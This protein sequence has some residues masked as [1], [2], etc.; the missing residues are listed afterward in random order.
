MS[1]ALANRTANAIHL[2]TTFDA[3]GSTAA[4][5]R[6]FAMPAVGDIRNR[7][8][9]LADTAVLP[10]R[11]LEF[12]QYRLPLAASPAD[13]DSTSPSA[14]TLRA[15]LRALAAGNHSLWHD[16]P[17]EF[18]QP[19]REL[20]HDCVCRL[21]QNFDP[22]GACLGNLVICG[23]YLRHKRDF[24]PV[25]ALIGQLLHVRGRVV[26]IVDESLH[27]ACVQD[28]G[29]MVVGQQHFKKL[30]R[31]IDRLLLTVHEPRQPELGPAEPIA[32]RPPVSEVARHYIATADIICYPMGSFYSSV[33]ANL[34]PRGVGEAIAANP[35][36]KIFIPNSGVDPEVCSLPLESH[37][38][39][40]LSILR[41]DAPHARDRDFL[42]HVLVD[43]RNG[44]YYCD[45]NLA[46]FLRER[47]IALHD[48]SLVIPGKPGCH[49]A[50]ATLNALLSL[51]PTAPDK[52]G[53][54]NNNA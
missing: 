39:A 36:P 13:S 38:T 3:G 9:A 24:G 17:G 7:M 53:K 52:S 37:V 54:E 49:D 2:V 33:L 50:E 40:L 32:C 23:G 28:D 47:D 10:P 31:R 5:R 19:L 26:P 43:S 35:C 30:S 14:T 21:P 44:Q 48:Q 1:R 29:T 6:A 8:L 20:L 16:M 22:F 12:M 42:N 41:N 4:L 11:V 27:L 51:L 34:L 46:A 25:L 18:A 15:E 45:A